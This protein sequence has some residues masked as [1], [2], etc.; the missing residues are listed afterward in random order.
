MGCIKIDAYSELDFTPAMF[1]K[2]FLGFI[3]LK[4]EAQTNLIELK[5]IV[6][7]ERAPLVKVK[8]PSIQVGYKDNAVTGLRVLLRCGKTIVSPRHT[9]EGFQRTIMSA[10]LPGSE[11]T[12]ARPMKSLLLEYQIT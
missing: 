8:A 1:G 6:S 5:D 7:F 11:I 9:V 4:E 3:D 10:R 12:V 2:S